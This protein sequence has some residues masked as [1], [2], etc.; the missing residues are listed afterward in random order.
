MS[1]YMMTTI[2]LHRIDANETLEYDQNQELNLPQTTDFKLVHYVIL[3]MTVFAMMTPI[4][5]HRIDDQNPD[6]NLPHATLKL[7]QN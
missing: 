6:I 3:V 4:F 1:F 7:V 2:F 5:L